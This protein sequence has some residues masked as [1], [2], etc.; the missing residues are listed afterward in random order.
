EEHMIKVENIRRKIA[1]KYINE[2]KEKLITILKESIQD[3]LNRGHN[4]ITYIDA[5]ELIK[6]LENGDI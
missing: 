5:F 6:Y 3:E 4:G 1:Q 2:Y